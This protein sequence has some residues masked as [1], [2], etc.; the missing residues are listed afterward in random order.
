MQR[1]NYGKHNLRKSLAWVLETSREVMSSDQAPK[2]FPR[3]YT[4]GM[5]RNP[6]IPA[7]T[8]SAVCQNL[9][10]PDAPFPVSIPEADITREKKKILNLIQSLIG[11]HIGAN[12][13]PPSTLWDR[14][15]RS[16]LRRGCCYLSFHFDTDTFLL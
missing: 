14:A 3:N 12:A 5:E 16:C 1:N 4:H 8:I 15:D 7:Y 10:Y 11:L 13:Q 2:A 6:Y 9:T